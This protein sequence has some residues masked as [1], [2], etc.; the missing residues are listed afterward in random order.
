MKTNLSDVLPVAGYAL[1]TARNHLQG[2]AKA[3][4]SGIPDGQRFDRIAAKI[5]RELPEAERGPAALALS[6][7]RK[8]WRV[9]RANTDN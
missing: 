9:V 8:A 2:E 1:A 5:V 3:D 4:L 7:Y 6:V